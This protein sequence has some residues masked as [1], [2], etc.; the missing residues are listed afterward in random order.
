MQEAKILFVGADRRTH[1]AVSYLQKKRFP[2]SIYDAYSSDYDEI[3]QSDIIVSPIPFSRDGISITGINPDL[4]PISSFT[5]LLGNKHILFGSGFLQ[6]IVELCE[7]KNVRYYDLM[8]DAYFCQENAR[9]SAEALIFEIGSVI[10]FSL[11][12]C[13]VIV[14]G[15]G[16]CGYHIV[17]LLK[18]LGAIPIVLEKDEGKRALATSI[19]L[20]SITECDCKASVC[21][22]SRIFINTVTEDILKF[23]LLCKLRPNCEV[24][25][26]S[27][28]KANPVDVSKSGVKYRDCPGLPAKY[29]PES[30]GIALGKAIERNLISMGTRINIIAH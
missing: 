28:I 8:K 30:A 4:L 6:G 20:S 2:V 10:P 11:S 5:G 21:F 16:H 19:G 1:F 29:M 24:F 17:R 3:L 7:E 14:A 25:N 15:Y 18:G 13:A 9:I 12:S 23:D 26:I 22:D 27:S